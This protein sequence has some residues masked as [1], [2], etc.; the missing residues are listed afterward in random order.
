MEVFL[1]LVFFLGL[2][3]SIALI[4]VGLIFKLLRRPSKRILKGGVLSISLSVLSFVIM[5]GM[6][7][8]ETSS[9]PEAEPNTEDKVEGTTESTQTV[10]QSSSE[11]EMTS[12]SQKPETDEEEKGTRTNPVPFGESAMRLID[13]NDP[14]QNFGFL[15]LTLSNLISG[16][17]AY[18]FLLNE[19][20]FNEQAP[21]G[22]QWIVFDVTAELIEGSE[23]EPYVSYPQISTVSESGSES[24]DGH[25]AVVNEEYGGDDLYKGGTNTGKIATIAPVDED[26]TIKWIEDY[27]EPV[28]FDNE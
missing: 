23:N 9:V 17:E 5:M 6:N 24:P 19:N 25:Y 15:R 18:N 13:I 21:E 10:E 22:Y 11:E 12:N 20:Q 28:F 26:Y 16:E 1:S 27:G 14:D 4:G 2:V 7:L 3:A 8:G